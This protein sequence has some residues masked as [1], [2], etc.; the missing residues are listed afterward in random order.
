MQPLQRP[1][2]AI[3]Q[4]RIGS[5]RLPGKVL[6]PILGKPLLWWHLTRLQ[7]CRLLDGIVVATTEEPGAEEIA[8]IAAELGVAVWR[9]PLDDVLERYRGAAA[10]SAAATVVR[11]TS[12]C[13]VIDPE[14][15]DRLIAAYHEAEPRIDYLSLDVSRLPR[16][17]DAEIFSAPLLE[18]AA[19]EARDPA[20]R[21]HVTAFLY[22]RPERF[23]I[24][25]MAPDDAAW[26]GLRLCVDTAED[27]ALVT[28][29]IEALAPMAPRFGWADIARL[30]D[31]NPEWR[32]LN[33]DV[34][35][36][37]P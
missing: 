14:L 9:G 20:E 23:M 21:E 17:L 35:Q 37:A 27:F 26:P 36:K 2:I 34:V 5:T 19:R 28:R 15:V 8:A 11:V 18:I 22:R 3:T 25:A 7:R 12:D 10:A 4:A 1:V 29:V 16:G 32:R 6:K 30:L 24:D 13:P 33:A 31:A